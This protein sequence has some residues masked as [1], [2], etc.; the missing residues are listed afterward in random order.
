MDVTPEQVE[1]GHALYTKR[2]LRV[3]DLVVL[4]LTSRLAWKCPSSRIVKHYDDHVSSN[5]LDIGVGT[6]YFLEKCRF[7]SSTPRV[8]MMDLSENCLDVAGRRIARYEPERYI[9]NVLEPLR[10]QAPKFDSVGMNYLLH[11]LPGT[12]RSK[13]VA[14]ANIKP[15]VNPGGVVFGA[16]MLYDGVKKN[17]LARRMMDDLN[18]RRVFT[19]TADDL[20]GLRWGLEQ[21]L[22]DTH[23]EIVGTAAL[24]WGRV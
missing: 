8:A 12:I 11:C 14:F 1:A 5:H 23:I 6:G 24:F 2:F 4:S 13:A 16:T 7:P 20:E 18:D 22:T 10:I 15:L 21:H 9:A 17:L 19:N 3:Y